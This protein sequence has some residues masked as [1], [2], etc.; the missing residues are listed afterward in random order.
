MRCY[1]PWPFPT[2]PVISAY[3]DE[4]LNPMGGKCE[5]GGNGFF[6]TLPTG[7]T[8][9]SK[10]IHCSPFLSLPFLSSGG[11]FSTPYNFSWLGEMTLTLLRFRTLWRKMG[12]KW[13]TLKPQ[14]MCHFFTALNSLFQSATSLIAPRKKNTLGPQALLSFFFDCL[15]C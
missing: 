1:Q 13:V 14:E 15:Q 2:P 5:R 6:S 10:F 4:S 8:S 12:I 9:P 11:I 7:G 3:S